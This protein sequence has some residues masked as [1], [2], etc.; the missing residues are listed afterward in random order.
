M[1]SIEEIKPYYPESLQV[2]E[3]FLLGRG[4]T[5]NYAYLS[6]KIG[7]QTPQELKQKILEKCATLDMKEMAADVKPFLF[8]PE[9]EK[10]ILLFPAYLEGLI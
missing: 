9:D 7:V 6:E 3:R 5:P 10:K 4:Q 8:N 2:F 1:L